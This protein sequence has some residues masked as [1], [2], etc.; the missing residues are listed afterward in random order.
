MVEGPCTETEVNMTTR[1]LSD[2]ER[3]IRTDELLKL[4]KTPEERANPEEMFFQVVHQSMELWMKSADHD[5]DR[6]KAF[7]E[8]DDLLRA[9]HLLRR[10]DA[11][12][13]HLSSA[14]PIME[15]LAPADYHEIRLALGQ[16][17]GQDS[18]GFQAVMAKLPTLWPVFVDTLA[19][20]E[21]EL[22]DLLA[23]PHKR[24]HQALYQLSQAMLSID[25]AFQRFRYYHLMLARRE[26]GL[27]VKSLKGVPARVM[28]KF[29][30]KAT[31]PELWTAIEVL[32]EKTSASY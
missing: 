26:I 13:G 18:P 8:T 16:G 19:R 2:Y 4:Q 23:E 21:I 30:L 28:E 32:T 9:S 31:F 17:S 5:L 24:E 27:A 20:H 6:V 1:E 29:V 10:G 11:I 15:T 14:L 22:D 25:E 7:M 3:Y 12:L